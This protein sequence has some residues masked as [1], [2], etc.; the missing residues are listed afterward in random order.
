[1]LI[2]MN[3][4]LRS[5]KG[6]STGEYAI[7]ITVLLGAIATIGPYM[8]RAF[9]GKMKTTADNVVET[10]KAEYAGSTLGDPGAV[11]YQYEP[12]YLKQQTTNEYESKDA[13]M[14]DKGDSFYKMDSTSKGKTGDHETTTAP[15][16]TVPSG[17]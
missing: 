16:G 6:S 1:M 8:Q 17:W 5:L 11:A 2:R 14:Y 9:Q 7:A 3:K 12:G 4:K 15:D 13:N 10:V